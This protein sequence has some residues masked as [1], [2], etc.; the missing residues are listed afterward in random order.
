MCIRDRSCSGICAW[1]AKICVSA[2]RTHAPSVHCQ[3]SQ[4]LAETRPVIHAVAFRTV[5]K[6][7]ELEMNFKR[8]A[9]GAIRQAPSVTT[10]IT[11][12]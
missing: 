2:A 4:K 11:S 6:K 3:A 10:W 9:R 12:L 1:A 7:D 8:S 5:P